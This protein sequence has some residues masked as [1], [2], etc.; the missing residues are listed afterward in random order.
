MVL[1]PF[2]AW[3]V[4]SMGQ[5]Q[6]S[7]DR[8]RQT[9]GLA[10]LTSM[11]ETDAANA[12]F[13]R[14]ETQP[15]GAGSNCSGVSGEDVLVV[16]ETG[17]NDPRRVVYSTAPDSEPSANGGALEL[18]RHVCNPDLSGRSSNRLVGDI[19]SAS[20]QCP[21]AGGEQ[22]DACWAVRLTVVPRNGVAATIE[23]VR[24]TDSTNPSSDQPTARFTYSPLRAER[25]RAV[26][27]NAGG[28][29]DPL[30]Q[31]LT[32]QWDW[33]DGTPV[34][35]T[36]NSTWSHT[37]ST[38]PDGQMGFP[39]TVTLT[40]SSVN[41]S[42]STTAQIAVMPQS[43]T[44]TLDVPETAF[45]GQ[46]ADYGADIDAGDGTALTCTWRFGSSA[47]EVVPCVSGQLVTP[48]TFPTVGV[49]VVELTVSSEYGQ[50]RRSGI[51]NVVNRLPEITSIVTRPAPIRRGTPMQLDTAAT[52]QVGTIA[53]LE[54]NWGDGSPITT[55]TC[56]GT[57]TCTATGLSHT[58]AAR[59]ARTIR[60]VA[61]DDLGDESAA[62][63]QTINVLARVS[64]ATFAT[65][66]DAS[67][68]NP[69]AGPSSISATPDVADE[70]VASYRWSL[71]SFPD[72]TTEVVMTSRSPSFANVPRGNYLL[73][74]TVTGLD[75]PAVSQSK[76]MLLTGAPTVA[77]G[78]PTWVASGCCDTWGEV[79][80]AVVPGADRY[81]VRYD[82]Y[83]GGGCLTDHSGTTAFTTPANNGS[84]VARVTAV[85]L[86]RGSAY[87]V[88]VRACVFNTTNSSCSW[89]PWSDDTWFR[90]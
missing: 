17:G 25:G 89:G 45:R 90:L 74:L 43:P 21:R 81:E 3:A 52:S 66:P 31:T 41:G 42:D 63:V 4:T 34:I 44:F 67:L 16:F 39:Y 65:T 33:G 37:F 58:Y 50:Q 70:D 71:R 48:R 26:V 24:R 59:G 22:N 46:S 29:W 11:F 56:P 77:P 61:V 49:R 54:I 40:V 36:T 6:G 53:R 13:A 47:P 35:T 7:L 10:R 1:G 84:Y 87:W 88:S 14:S 20:A 79:S 83:F 12:V 85:G 30:N 23:G 86:C 75:D 18:N 28:S 27:F 5:Q 62:G 73:E 72:L 9:A 76:R 38:F 51:V 55:Y 19:Q 80:F 78:A 82:G 32:Y 64:V 8:N 2:F 15:S 69:A 60:V 68:T 57:A